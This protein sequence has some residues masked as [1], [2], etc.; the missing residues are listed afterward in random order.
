MNVL[1]GV[2]GL[3]V[4]PV[5]RGGSQETCQCV[6]D[7]E[8]SGSRMRVLCS[9]HPS[10]PHRPL[11]PCRRERLSEAVSSAWPAGGALPPSD[12]APGTF[13][14]LEYIFYILECMPLSGIA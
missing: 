13:R 10:S 11:C 2:T 1:A 4:V 7:A 9:P 6:C 3:Q 8:R 14:Q 12:P 5:G